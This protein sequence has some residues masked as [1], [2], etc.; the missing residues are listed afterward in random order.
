MADLIKDDPLA[1][2]F[3]K[4]TDTLT[5]WYLSGRTFDNGIND[6]IIQYFTD[7]V[8]GVYKETTTSKTALQ[9]VATGINT[10]L[11][12]YGVKSGVTTQSQ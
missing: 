7:A 11:T 12:Q 2:A 4:Q 5:S 8:N 9:T 1:G 3:V 6:K 10:V